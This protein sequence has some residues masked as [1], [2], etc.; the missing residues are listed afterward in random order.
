MV[1][2]PAVLNRP[3]VDAAAGSA[4]LS[5]ALASPDISGVTVISRRA[6][7][8]TH[9]KLKTILLPSSEHSGTFEKLPPSIL[10]AVRD[11]QGVIWA[12]GVSSTQVKGPEYVK[13]AIPSLCT[14]GGLCSR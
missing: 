9:P 7:P 8:L 12:L 11:H 10:D 3:T 2:P 13:C 4:T 14:R 1:R 5:A 6:P